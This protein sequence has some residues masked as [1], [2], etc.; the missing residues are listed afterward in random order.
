MRMFCSHDLP[1][2]GSALMSLGLSIGSARRARLHIFPIYAFRLVSW[3]LRSLINSD[4]IYLDVAD[5]KSTVS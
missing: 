1:S 5:R 3:S 2:N 4:L